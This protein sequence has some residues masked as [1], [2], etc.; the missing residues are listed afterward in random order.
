[1]GEPWTHWDPSLELAGALERDEFRL[2]YQ[3]VV[4]LVDGSVVGAE[5][6]LRWVH[7]RRGT[8]LPA[9]FLPCLEDEG[10]IVAV[11]AWALR[12]ACAEAARWNRDP[13]AAPRSV[14]VNVSGH[15]AAD[16]R[17]VAHVEEA[18]EESGVDPAL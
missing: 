4:S 1:M 18:L 5:A 9:R 17:M 14:G 16:H 13:A 12:T 10:L 7:P 11:G 6:L 15:Q 3:P 8:L 2:V